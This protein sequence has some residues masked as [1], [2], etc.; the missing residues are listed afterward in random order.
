VSTFDET[1]H[2]RGT[3]GR[4]AEKHQ[5]DA[6]IS[7]DDSAFVWERT[8]EDQRIQWTDKPGIYANVIDSTR[9][10]HVRD[11]DLPVRIPKWDWEV[12]DEFDVI[13]E[14][15]T[16]S[17]EDAK[18][19]AEAA[20][21]HHRRLAA[22]ARLPDGIGDL[23]IVDHEPGNTRAIPV[24]ERCG[25]DTDGP[26]HICRNG[27]VFTLWHKPE[28]GDPFPDGYHELEV[29]DLFDESPEAGQWAIP[30]PTGACTSCLGEGCPYC[31]GAESDYHTECI[32]APTAPERP[33][34]RHRSL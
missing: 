24:I 4:F 23:T 14:G 29:S 18:S 9:E 28:S 1:Q 16:G 20:L 3:A 6:G 11:Y 19:A 10:G 15:S 13:A 32:P 12:R 30:V 17:E 34:R 31:A 33:A 5:T 27:G 7:L 25:T 26:E 8:P 2:P 22:I 21:R